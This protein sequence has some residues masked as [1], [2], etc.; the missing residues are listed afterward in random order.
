MAIAFDAATD[1]GFSTGTSHTFAHTCTGSDRLLF[2][3]IAGDHPSGSDDITGVTYNGAAMTLVAKEANAGLDR[4]LYL[5]VLIAPATGANNVVVSATNVHDIFA[6]AVS[7][8]GAKQTGQPDNSTTNV[9]GASPTSL[10]TSLTPVADSCWTIVMAGSYAANNAPTAGTGSTRRTYDGTFGTWGLFDS[11]AAI[12]PAASYSMTTGYPVPA[13]NP[14]GHV[15][16]SFAPPG[17]GGGGGNP[18]YAYA[19]Q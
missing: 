3:G 9:S 11:N 7:Y 19:Q 10:T 13:S 4:I 2:V 8:T 18:W 6:G 1:G 14:I 5:Y 17:G 15:M 16:A 12:S